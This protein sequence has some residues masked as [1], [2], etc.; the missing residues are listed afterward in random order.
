VPSLLQDLDD[1]VLV[2]WKDLGKSVGPF[3]VVSE[4]L[5]LMRGGL[6]KASGV[7]D[8]SAESKLAGKAL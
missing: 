4:F 8:I 3:D 5:D 2:L 1:M 7:E 6:G